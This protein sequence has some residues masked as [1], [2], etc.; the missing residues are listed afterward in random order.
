VLVAGEGAVEAGANTGN[1]GRFS[2][3]SRD[4]DRGDDLTP[5]RIGNPDYSKVGDPG[6]S[7]E[8]QLDL[9]RGDGLAA[10]PDDLPEAA[11]YV[12]EAVVVQHADV[13]GVV[14]AVAQDGSCL[15]F[16]LVVTGHKGRAPVQDF[17][18]SCKGYEPWRSGAADASRMVVEL[19]IEQG[20]V[21]TA[22]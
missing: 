22:F 7:G 8:S 2:S 13:A 11:G 3:R 14:P 20:G 21:V 16:Q 5:R 9:G 6:D 4:Y 18:F 15:I 12:K 19:A 17:S 1:V 10:G